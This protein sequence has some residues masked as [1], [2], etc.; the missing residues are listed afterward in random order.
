MSISKRT[1]YGGAPP[2]KSRRS[3]RP[4]RFTHFLRGTTCGTLSVVARRKESFGR[5]RLRH[6]EQHPC[7][8]GRPRPADGDRQHQPG[9]CV[10]HVPQVQGSPS[11]NTTVAS[12]CH[13]APTARPSAS[14]HAAAGRESWT[15]RRV[16]SPARLAGPLGP[17]EVHR[18]LP[19]DGPRKQRSKVRA[20][21]P[22]SER[23][24][25]NLSR[26]VNRAPHVLHRYRATAPLLSCPSRSPPDPQSCLVGTRD[27][28]ARYHPM[29][30]GHPDQFPRP[31][32]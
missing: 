3:P 22:G 26:L 23:R 10:Q 29:C 16:D 13:W 32:L 2:G 25:R 4:R 8:A 20:I 21:V 1:E 28:P 5:R 18:D 24:F 19:L 11:T 15:G 27:L 9:L 31:D 7:A 17:P 6:L 14:R 30:Y 12:M